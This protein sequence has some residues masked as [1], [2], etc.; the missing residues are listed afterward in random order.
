MN[1]RDIYHKR[2]EAQGE[3]YKDSFRNQSKMM[4]NEL[5]LN[6]YDRVDVRVN[7]TD[8]Y[9]CIVRDIDGFRERKFNFPPETKTSLGDYIEHDNFIYLVMKS[10]TDDIYPRAETLLCNYDFPIKVE[11]K[12]TL[13]GKLDNG[14]PDY[15]IESISIT[16]PC[17]L[18]TK[19][20]STADNSSVPLP[21]GSAVIYL[22]YSQADR[23]PQVNFKITHEHAQYK[24]TDWSY[25]NVINYKTAN[26]K[27][28][29][30]RIHLQREANTNV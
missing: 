15:L 1:Y 12:K 9:P 5:L 13:V 10:N 4:A 11:E 26:E 29:Y 24:I 25:D 21:D 30:I 16:K 28:G 27:K 6:S 14:R 22:P 7:F 20:Y 18:T 8:N 23:P 19:L 3:T 2:H 17:V